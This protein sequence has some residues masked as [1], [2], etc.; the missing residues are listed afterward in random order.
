MFMNKTGKLLARTA[1]SALSLII[2]LGAFAMLSAT[3]GTLR[4]RAEVHIEGGGYDSIVT[5]A[6][7]DNDDLPL[8]YM[9]ARDGD[10]YPDFNDDP[11][12]HDIAARAW[13]IY[14]MSVDGE[15]C[16][17][18][19]Y[20]LDGLALT[21][22]PEV[23]AEGVFAMRDY[24]MDDPDPNQLWVLDYVGTGDGYQFFRIHLLGSE[25]YLGYGHGGFYINNSLVESSEELIFA[26]GP[27]EKYTDL[28]AEDITVT[29]GTST[30]ATVIT[31]EDN[32]NSAAGYDPI[33]E[34]SV[35]RNL[36]TVGSVPELP[37][38]YSEYTRGNEVKAMLP[39]DD[40]I[41]TVITMNDVSKYLV[42]GGT[43]HISDPFTVEEGTGGI[44]AAT[45]LTV[46]PGTSTENTEFSW[47]S[48]AAGYQLIVEEYDEYDAFVDSTVLAEQSGTDFS[49]PLTPGSYKAKVR[50]ID[51]AGTAFSDSQPVSFTVPEDEEEPGDSVYPD[52]FYGFISSNK[53]NTGSGEYGDT[54]RRPLASSAIGVQPYN[55]SSIDQL[56]LF[57]KQSDGNYVI[58]SAKSNNGEVLTA[59]TDGTVK[60]LPYEGAS[61]QRWSLDG[62]HSSNTRLSPKNDDRLLSTD[63]STVFLSD[64]DGITDTTSPE[65]FFICTH[66]SPDPLPTKPVLTVEPGIL[67]AP[68]EFKWTECGLLPSGQYRLL[69]EPVEVESPDGS[70]LPTAKTYIIMPEPDTFGTEAGRRYLVSDLLP[71]K[72]R[73]Y[74]VADNFEYYGAS[75][76]SNKV[77][78]TVEDGST[79]AGEVPE[80]NDDGTRTYTIPCTFAGS[81]KEGAVPATMTITGNGQ[82][83]EVTAAYS[84]DKKGAEFAV[85]LDDGKTYDIEITKPGHIPYRTTIKSGETR[86]P[87]SAALIPGDVNEDGV[88]N[89]KDHAALTD[90]WGSK[91]G[92]A[93]TKYRISGDFDEDG[94]ITGLDR[95]EVTKN[96]GASAG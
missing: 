41:V 28:V 83:G 57:E 58:H 72:Y 24:D 61:G 6:S 42:D 44:P 21:Y 30:T 15:D 55:S 52:R 14:D 26:Y 79:P 48:G 23:T 7:V 87:V 13:N 92:D 19:V 35:H 33:Y 74:I 50:A 56:W 46:D 95:S 54:L 38:V 43:Y 53:Y 11:T 17:F 60:A 47:M 63:G 8:C 85:R 22:T 64:D 94:N 69:V 34:V 80:L 86:S 67:P 96:F 65:S 62:E 49:A 37:V 90:M 16:T 51:A 93:N 45:T 73:A 29:P 36:D 25:K 88:I 1:A 4:A 77:E 59:G 20:G 70:Q 9:V 10:L 91:P 39:A 3:G 75:I 78:F 2:A 82:G 68:T 32:S 12:D 5:K 76:A 66:L 81:E 89:V 31:W 40:Y 18:L 84:A 27:R 71:G